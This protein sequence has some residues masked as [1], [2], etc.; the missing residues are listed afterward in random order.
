MDTELSSTAEMAALGAPEGPEVE[1]NLALIRIEIGPWA[2]LVSVFLGSPKE[3][4]A[5]WAVL[6]GC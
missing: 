3:K 5:H 2:T 6:G 1:G 4:E